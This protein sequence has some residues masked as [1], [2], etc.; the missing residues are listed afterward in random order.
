M[1]ARSRLKD[2]D[3]VER[4]ARRDAT[5]F[6][7]PSVAAQRLGWIGLPARVVA[8]AAAL[9]ELAESVR[10]TAITDVVLLGMGGSSLAPLV[11]ARTIGTA[12]GSPTLHVLDTTSPVQ[13]DT[14]LKQL[15]PAS[16]MVVVSSKSGST[17]EPLSLA[18]VFRAWMDPLVGEHAGLHFAAVTDP[19]S[20]LEEYAR[21]HGFAAVFHAPADVGGRFAA[22]TPFATV[23]AA[24]IGIDTAQLGARAQALETA[25]MT[26]SEANPAAA[27]ASWMA[28]AADNGRDKLTLVVSEPLA[29]FGRWVEQLVA[30]STGKGGRGILPVLEAAPGDP[31]SHGTDRMVF[32]LRTADDEPLAALRSY[33]PIDTPAF[34]VVVDDPYDLAAEFV[35]WEWAVALFSAVTGIEPFDQPDVATAKAATDAI[36]GGTLHAPAPDL[37]QGHIAITTGMTV[38]PAPETSALASA[39]GTLLT[40]T[41]PGDYLAVLAYL[42]EDERLI[43]PV[44]DACA[45]VARARRMAVTFELGPRY[46]HSTGQYHK[47][48]PAN[49]RFLIITARDEVGPSVPGRRFTLA[50]LNRAQAEGDFVTLAATGVP[51]VRVDLPESDPAPI[52]LVAETLR[53]A[54]G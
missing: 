22:L 8:D 50:Q 2:L 14:L 24:L 4:L 46:L 49:G 13:I 53:G 18:S 25:C 40:G 44:R 34:E 36:L 38:T 39:L 42:P 43:A 3:A 5:L 41:G 29:A 7:D 9:D 52:R 17:I 54:A 48:G 33:L 51:V 23:P 6:A 27:L 26:E 19:G 21:R 15:W 1:D 16:T 47:G 12:T 10:S 37:A 11:L 20:P 30:E 31:A 28:D 45:A 32:I 35:R